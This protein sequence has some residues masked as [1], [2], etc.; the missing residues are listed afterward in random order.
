M[1]YFI[2]GTDTDC[3]KTYVTSLLLAYFQQQGHSAVGYKP[4]CSGGRGD[5]EILLRASSPGSNL[6]RLNPCWFHNALSPYAASLIENRPV[7]MDK[8]VAGYDTLVESYDHVLVEGAGGWETPL[9]ATETIADLATALQLPVL[10]VVN[11]R[12]GAINHAL[13]TLHG[14]VSRGLVCQ[15]IILNH[16]VDERDP[17]SISNRS[18]LEKFTSIPALTELIHGATELPE[19]VL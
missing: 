6:D 19:F 8:L 4:V 1:H 3:G 12:L 9:T 13:L 18:I 10:L 11:N 14:I 16:P 15:G 5:A 17:A 2:T 7:I